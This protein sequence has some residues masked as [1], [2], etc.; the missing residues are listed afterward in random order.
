MNWQLN[1]NKST[2]WH[3]SF[4]RAKE[5]LICISFVLCIFT[6]NIYSITARLGSTYKPQKKEKQHA[7]FSLLVEKKQTI[8]SQF[9]FIQM[10]VI[11]HVIID[12]ANNM[13]ENMRN[14]LRSSF[15]YNY[16]YRCVFIN[17]NKMII[18]ENQFI[19]NT[20]YHIEQKY[21]IISTRKKNCEMLMIS[22]KYI[23]KFFRKKIVCVLLQDGN[24]RSF[25]V[26]IKQS[27]Q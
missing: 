17:Q 1:S 8:L 14:A 15:E 2:I 13:R 26:L 16:K 24:P 18:K 7:F 22:N 27:H 19:F 23:C 21:N 20:E 5:L 3:F 25:F 9:G 11:S 12:F 6:Y 4:I 10:F